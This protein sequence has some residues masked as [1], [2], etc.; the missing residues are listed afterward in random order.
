MILP[1]GFDTFGQ[2]VEV[3][4]GQCEALRE[5]E[6]IMR[7]SIIGLEA[8]V[9]AECY[10]GG[11]N[12]IVDGLLTPILTQLK[13]E[14]DLRILASKAI[15]ALLTNLPDL[16]GFWWDLRG[17]SAALVNAK[18]SYRAVI[19]AE[20]AV[21]AF[22]PLDLTWELRSPQPLPDEERTYRKSVIAQ[23][24]SA[25]K[26]K[27][28]L[29]KHPSIL[30]RHQTY[31]ERWWRV[32]KG[33]SI[34]SIDLI[35][36]LSCCMSTCRNTLEAFSPIIPIASVNNAYEI[37]MSMQNTILRPIAYRN[38]HLGGIET[39]I[40]FGA[41]Q[42]LPE[43]RLEV[44]IS[45]AA[46]LDQGSYQWYGVFQAEAESGGIADFMNLVINSPSRFEMSV[47]GMLGVC[48]F[49]NPLFELSPTLLQ[50]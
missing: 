32:L 46:G 45:E 25:E 27:T 3:V 43:S 42:F 20:N 38:Y 39:P 29:S 41:D 50:G 7:R 4:V 10:K 24:S 31:V 37:D 34:T 35:T 30:D 28:W 36:S 18:E 44:L 22:P 1:L 6:R 47:W 8:I 48:Q 9:D 23:H 14:I 2:S 12:E 16:R 26:A 5:I 11:S 19:E 40:L 33:S 21:E 13:Q 15:D 17:G 49:F